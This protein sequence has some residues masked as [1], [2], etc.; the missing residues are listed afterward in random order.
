MRPCLVKSRSLIF[1]SSVDFCSPGHDR[2]QM[3]MKFKPF[4]HQDLLQASL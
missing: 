3:G 1:Q 2:G 4:V